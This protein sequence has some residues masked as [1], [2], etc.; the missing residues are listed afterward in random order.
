MRIGIVSA[1]PWGGAGRAAHRLHKAFQS[2]GQLSTL[3]VRYGGGD[4]SIVTIA[5]GRGPAVFLAEAW[6]R[7]RTVSLNRRYLELGGD[8]NEPLRLDTA[9]QFAQLPDCLA[10]RDIVNLHWVADFVDSRNVA[11]IA[12]SVAPVVWTMHD[13]LPLS[14]GCHYDGGC[15][16]F[17]TGCGRCPKLQSSDR[18]DQTART[19]KRK[20]RALDTIPRDRLRVVTPSHWLADC[21]RCS[22]IFSGVAVSVIPN[23][24]DTDVFV[25]RDRASARRQFGF[26]P[27]AHVI[28]F[29]S[30]V[31]KTQRKGI[32]AL[33]AALTGMSAIEREKIVLVS[34]GSSPGELPLPLAQRHLGEISDDVILS[35]IY[36]AADVVALPSMQDNL[37]NTMIEA[38][39]CGTP[40][41]GFATGGIPDFVQSQITGSLV[42][43][44]DIDG[45][46]RSLLE[47]IAD[48]QARARMGKTGRALILQECR[49][50]VQASRYI[51]LFENMVA[52]H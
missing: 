45:L 36:S 31:V 15:G 22:P 7:R 29:M 26:P 16:G 40:V 23:S 4:E 30:H 14:G 6:V 37:P 9:P 27:E 35:K 8:Q 39:A 3:F 17:A 51:D 44:G 12:N 11:R 2:K 19:W 10:G 20:Q 38:L 49:P 24:I 1:Q 41:A 32:A 46:R 42:E 13:M 50:E 33:I 43:A 48:D 18:D 25:P 52:R 21:V 5:P 34:V 47:L 28:L